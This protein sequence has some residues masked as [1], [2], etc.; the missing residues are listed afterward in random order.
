MA[1]GVLAS[2]QVK[3]QHSTLDFTGFQEALFSRA[4]ARAAWQVI[5]QLQTVRQLQTAG[6]LTLTRICR[7]GRLH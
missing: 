5:R 7:A 4:A 2:P 1:C 3:F 6:C